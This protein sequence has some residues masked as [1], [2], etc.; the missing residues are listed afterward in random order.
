MK[1]ETSRFGRIDIEDDKII[2]L[3]DG[4][5]GFSGTRF[6][7]LTPEK[8]TPFR[9]LQSVDDPALAFVVVDA[10]Q[11]LPDYTVSLTAD[12]HSRLALDSKTEVVIL[13]VAT[14]VSETRSVTVNLQG[15]L[16]LNPD[17]MLAKQIVLEGNK[18]PTKFPLFGT[19][20]AADTKAASCV[21]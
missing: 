16:V 12:E 6:I 7:L 8:P 21:G 11:V 13:L 18:F 2:T 17:R 14:L 5:L 3:P 10:Q 20:P 4:M 9:W 15:P 1:I 19:A